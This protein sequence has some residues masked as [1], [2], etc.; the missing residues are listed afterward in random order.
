V[1]EDAKGSAAIVLDYTPH[2]DKLGLV[3][4]RDKDSQ[5]TAHRRLTQGLHQSA[6]RRE[7]GKDRPHVNKMYQGLTMSSAFARNSGQRT[8][9]AK[10]TS[11]RSSAE[12]CNRTTNWP[13]LVLTRNSY[14]PGDINVRHRGTLNPPASGRMSRTLVALPSMRQTRQTGLTGKLGDFSS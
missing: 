5:T 1:A 3:L 13:A 12:S 2:G 7:A 6:L 10:H 4:K 14:R 11:S 9:T 8:G